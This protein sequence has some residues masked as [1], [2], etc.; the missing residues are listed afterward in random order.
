MFSPLD[1]HFPPNP[2]A[3]GVL[4]PPVRN[5]TA[6][7]LGQDPVV[8]LASPWVEFTD[9]CSTDHKDQPNF[10]DWKGDDLEWER[11]LLQLR[12]GSC[13]SELSSPHLEVSL[14]LKQV[15]S[16][17]IPVQESAW[18]GDPKKCRPSIFQPFI[19]GEPGCQFL[20]SGLNVGF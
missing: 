2:F 19:G 1:T 15:Y 13:V 7:S 6:C 14:F 17:E 10:E 9:V 20:L 12:I 18:S 16:S 5:R 4:H 8:L 11:L 3:L